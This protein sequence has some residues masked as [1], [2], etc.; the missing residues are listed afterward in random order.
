MCAHVDSLSQTQLKKGPPSAP[1]SYLLPPGEGK[2]V[3]H[4]DDQPYSNYGEGR[5]GSVIGDQY[6]RGERQTTPP[7]APPPDK[8]VT[9]EEEI[10]LRVRGELVKSEEQSRI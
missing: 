5:K 1:P 10:N 4:Y 9:N 2:G 6:D 3:R 7:G 8:P